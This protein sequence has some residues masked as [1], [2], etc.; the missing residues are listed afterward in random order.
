[1]PGWL[2]RYVTLDM[3][4]VSSSPMRCVEITLK[5]SLKKVSLGR[6][7]RMDPSILSDSVIWNHEG[8]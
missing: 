8:K 3:G 7:E 6:K 2:S 5:N 1:M 4:V